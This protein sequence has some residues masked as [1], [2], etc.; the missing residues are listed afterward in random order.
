MDLSVNITGAEVGR[1]E[2]NI[3]SFSSICESKVLV[4]CNGDS[5]FD[6]SAHEIFIESLSSH[7]QKETLVPYSGNFVSYKFTD[8]DELSGSLIL[9][10]EMDGSPSSVLSTDTN[11]FQHL[12]DV[13]TQSSNFGDVSHTN[14]CQH[15]VVPRNLETS[16]VDWSNISSNFNEEYIFMHQKVIESG[17][18]N[19]MGCRMSVPSKLNISYWRSM[20]HSN[21][22]QDLELC[23]LLEFGFPIS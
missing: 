13:S 22:Y 14:F 11:I 4:P 7:G 17:I 23:D 15:A 10:N 9:V 12:Y 5:N 16:L 2:N 21:N 3:E 8:T 1:D 18:P 19:F 20:L 6:I